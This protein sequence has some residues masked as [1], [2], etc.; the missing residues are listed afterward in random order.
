M[1][2]KI[3]MQADPDTTSGSANTCNPHSNTETPT[4]VYRGHTKYCTAKMAAVPSQ[5][6]NTDL[7]TQKAILEQLFLKKE[8][9]GDFW[10]VVVAEWLEQLKRYIGIQSSRKFLY[11][12][13]SHPG[14]IITRRDYAHT[15]DV[16]HEDAWR[17]LVQ[18]YGLADGH[19]PMKLVVYA[20]SRAQEIEHNLNSFKVMLSNAPV[21][22][23]HNV[24]FSKLEKVGHV[25]WKLR[26]IYQI[27]KNE[28][29]R[30]W[31]KSDSDSDWQLLVDRDKS[32]GKI[33]NI[34]SDFT[35]PIIAMEICKEDG[36]WRNS[37]GSAPEVHDF[38]VGPLHER[39]IFDDITSNW[40]VDIHEQIDH[41]GKSMVENLHVNFNA[42]VQRAK[43][44]VDERDNNLRQRERNLCLRECYVDNMEKT[45]REKEKKLDSAIEDYENL[46]K[47]NEEKIENFEQEHTRKMEELET[48]FDSR[49]VELNRQRDIFEHERE[50]FHDELQKMSE[51]YRIQENK[52]KLDIGGQFFSTSLSTLTRDPSSMLA[53]M[54]SGRHQLK[55]EADGS[56]FIDRD[57]THFRYILNFL[58]DGHIKE[59]TLPLNETIQRELLAE[60][61]FYQISGLVEYLNS[62]LLK[63]SDSG[64]TLSLV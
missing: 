31:A 23:F 55:T 44:Y 43:E 33:L 8:I 35:R 15:V 2:S 54:F 17:M 10:Y 19:R 39:N 32:I 20:Y 42:F 18:W 6:I 30:L 36:V 50:N 51:M 22:E 21:E 59:G 9:E 26:D 34:D 53:A 12:T 58:R 3:K 61:E 38:A 1:C 4:A 48:V 41:L 13:R 47:I 28:K 11:H 46:I 64:D 49:L 56:H 16:V 52:I 27:H 63:R 24:R 14:P 57:G 45:M 5:N 40:E 62:L 60:A 25:E 37:P 7:P 29:T